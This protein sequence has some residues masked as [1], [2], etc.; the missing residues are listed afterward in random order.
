M[1]SLSTCGEMGF[2]DLQE[3]ILMTYRKSCYAWEEKDS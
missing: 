3:K 2:D 1:A